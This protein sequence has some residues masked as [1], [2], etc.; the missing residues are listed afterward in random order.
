MHVAHIKLFMRLCIIS[1]GTNIGDVAIWEV[2][3]RERL[4]CRNF[5]VRDLGG[6]TMILQ[7]LFIEPFVAFSSCG[8][9]N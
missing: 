5:K 1:V 9:D 2:A 6:C 7:V 8:F 3:S 4:A